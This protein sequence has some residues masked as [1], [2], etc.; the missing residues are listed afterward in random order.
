[1]VDRTLCLK[2]DCAGLLAATP[3]I[4]QER[5][6]LGYGRI[7][8]NDFF[9]DNED[10]WRSGS[11]AFSIVRG[12]E[13]DGARP[14]APGAMIEYRLRSEIIAPSALNGPGQTD[15]AYVGALSAGVHTHFA[16]GAANISAGVDLIATGP[17]AGILDMQDGFHDVISAPNPSAFV[18]DNQV[19]NAVHPTA[20]TEVSYRLPMGEATTLRP[21]VEA[22]YG[23]ED[24]VRVGA[25]VL[26][27]EMLQNDMWLRDSP[28]G[29]LYTGVETGRAGT[30]FV[31]GADYAAV[32]DSAY[33][34]AS[35]GTVAQEERFRARAGVHW[36]FGDGISY[37]YGV[38]YLSEEFEGQDG[39]Q[40]L[41]SL[42]LNFN[43]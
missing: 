31:L 1:M 19:A 29:Q 9:G 30:G 40:I 18:A 5:E 4:A 37:F 10:R 16:R 23:V 21:F 41:G 25:D 7:F 6:T 33:F 39:G 17:Q 12:P 15:R 14:A 34:P 11:Y 8:T 24:F 26:I 38:T 28:S 3:A 2:S 27:G 36:R 32:S 22:Q 42:K 13:W 43:F 35:F 20:L